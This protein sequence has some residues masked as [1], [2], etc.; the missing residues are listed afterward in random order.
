MG[1]E[2]PKRRYHNRRKMNRLNVKVNGLSHQGSSSAIQNIVKARA[3]CL[4]HASL[5]RWIYTRR[6]LCFTFL[7]ILYH[8]KTLSVLLFSYFYI[9]YLYAQIWQ[10]INRKWK[11]YF[12]IKWKY[13][14]A[15]YFIHTSIMTSNSYDFVYLIL[16][17]INRSNIVYMSIDF[18]LLK[19]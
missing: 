7:L 14:I 6:G 19:L 9:I 12:C 17:P 1:Q 8:K 10:L 5:Y 4:L 16:E 2:K 11:V 3:Q 18:D 13:L 15:T